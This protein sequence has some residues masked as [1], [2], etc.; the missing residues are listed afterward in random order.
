V[1]ARLLFIHFLGDEMPGRD[2]PK[3]EHEWQEVLR[4][5][6]D[7]LGLGGTSAIEKRVHKLFLPVR[8]ERDYWTN[9]TDR[10]EWP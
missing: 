3:T 4:R 8:A 2:C 5:V 10:V 6:S 7:H 9:D 1:S